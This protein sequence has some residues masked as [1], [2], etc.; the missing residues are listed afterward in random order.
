MKPRR[1][2]V[3]F[4]LLLIF[5]SCEAPAAWEHAR[6][7]YVFIMISDGSGYNHIRAA[8]CFRGGRRRFESFPLRYAVSTFEYG[9]SYDPFEACSDFTYVEFGATD[10]ASAATTLSTG[11]KTANGRIGMSY[12]GSSP[13]AHAFEYAE[14]RGYSTG[15]ITSVQWS[16]AT[17]AGF[18]AHNANRDDY[19]NIAREMIFESRT[20]VVMGCGHP[21]FDDNGLERVFGCDYTYVG[22][23]TTWDSLASGS[24]GGDADGDG[25]PD[26]WTLVTGKEDFEKY[27]NHVLSARRLC[28]TA[29]VASTLQEERARTNDMVYGDAYVSTVPS[30]ATMAM[31]GIN[32]LSMNPRGF[33]VMIEGGAI[34]KA[35]HANRSNRAIEER[36]DFDSA[37]DAVIGW[38]ERYSNWEESLLIVTSDHETGYLN[39]PGSDPYLKPITGNGIGSLPNMAWYT[40]GHTNSL[41]PLFAR[42]SFG[43]SLERYVAGMDPMRGKYIDN[44]AIGKLLVSLYR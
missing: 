9:G 15:V 27:A 1:F 38:I 28:G 40:T 30:L 41:V 11:V 20:D 35:S 7:R 10:S 37:V 2:T 16:H 3:P 43:R 17:P 21:M 19:E 23:A 39:G 5:L 4:S 29:R 33:V 31:A 42:G 12:D 13:L 44:T 32:V 24:A 34:D 36:I 22:G 26:P 25:D 6:P 14:N 18:V 8:D